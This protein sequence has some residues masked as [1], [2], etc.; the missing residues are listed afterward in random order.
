MFIGVLT[1]QKTCGWENHTFLSWPYFGLVT[2]H[3]LPRCISMGC[4]SSTRL[5][6]L[7]VWGG[8]LA[9]EMLL[10][11]SNIQVAL[12]A[13]RTPWKMNGWN[14]KIIQLKRKVIFQAS[15]SGFKM[16]IFRGVWLLVFRIIGQKFWYYYKGDP[17]NPVLPK[18]SG[19]LC[20]SSNRLGDGN[21]YLGYIRYM[22]NR[23]DKPTNHL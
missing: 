22:Q 4:I 10:A 1:S 20:Q 19:R 12:L 3:N 5:Y 11:T 18:A 15:V 13:T 8:R 9:S 6:W 16:W 23:L 14:L 17:A 21:C 2:Y 7:R